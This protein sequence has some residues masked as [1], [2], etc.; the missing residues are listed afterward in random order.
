MAMAQ[1]HETFLPL[2]RRSAD[3]RERMIVVRHAPLADDFGLADG[4]RAS[5]LTRLCTI[6]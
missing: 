3:G 6:A 4:E 5:I 1:F 2:L